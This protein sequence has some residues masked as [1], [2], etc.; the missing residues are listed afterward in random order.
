MLPR[1][2]ALIFDHS[3]SGAGTRRADTTM[4]KYRADFW[5]LKL[6]LNEVRDRRQ[7]QLL[8]EMGWSVMVLWECEVRGLHSLTARIARIERSSGEMKPD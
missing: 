3:F 1:Y 6:E 5:T 8:S 2:R 7:Q 4:P